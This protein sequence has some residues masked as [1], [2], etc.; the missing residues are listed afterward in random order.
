MEDSATR[1]IG[2]TPNPKQNAHILSRLTF[3]YIFPLFFKGYRRTI[4]EDDVFE[5]HSEL[6]S[7]N[8]GAIGLDLWKIELE[9]ASEA[10]RKPSLIK[11]LTKI[12]LKDY[13]LIGAGIFLAELILRPLQAFFLGEFIL[14]YTDVENERQPYIYASCVIAC[15]FIHTLIMHPVLYASF[16]L[17]FRIR[18]VCGNLIYWKILKLSKNALKQSTPG[19]ILNLIS[20]DVNVF[21]KLVFASQFLWAAPFQAIIVTSLMYREV[22]VSSIFGVGLF[23]LFIPLYFLFGQLVAKFRSK[24]STMRDQRLRFMNEIIQGIGVI[25]M[26]AWEK[27]FSTTILN[28]RKME[29]NFTK[30][31]LLVKSATLIFD[32]FISTSLFITITSGVF[33]NQSFNPKSVFIVTTLLAILGVTLNFLLPQGMIFLSE[34]LVSLDRITDFLLSNEI[35]RKT[36]ATLP[37]GSISITNGTAAWDKMPILRNLNFKIES[38][39]LNAII[40]PIASGKTSLLSLILGEMP[41]TTGSL[42]VSGTISYAPQVAWIFS[43]TIKQNILFG[44]KMDH[45]RYDQVI[46]CCA[47]ERDLKLLPH[48]DQT[49]VGERGSSL[50]GG[51]KARINLARAIYREA[52]IYLLDDPLSA[53]DTEVG[54][55]IFEQ[56]I[57]TFLKGKTVMLVTHQ[58][59]YLKHINSI[60]VLETGSLITKG[61]K[62]E[63]ENSGFDFVHFLQETDMNA[64]DPP[65]ETM[66]RY[67]AAHTASKQPTERLTT[68]LIT[69]RTYKDYFFASKDC[70]I[71]MVPVLL[72]ILVQLSVS[73][74]YYFLAYWVNVEHN[75]GI[76]PEQRSAYLY[77]YCS[78]ILAALILTVCR[79]L[80]FVKLTATSSR[81]LHKRM[82]D[83]V[84]HA[85]LG[86]FNLNSSGVILNRFSKDL[87]TIDELLPNAIMIATRTV[88]AILGV[89]CVICVVNPWFIIPTLLV[90]ATL[91]FLRRFY[92]ATDLNVLR[93][94]GQVRGPL[95]SHVNA[96]LH[97]LATI[98]AFGM[99]DLLTEEFYRHQ[100]IHT[101]ALDMAAIVSRAFAYW[102]DLLNV[103]YIVVLTLYYTFNADSYGGNIGLII[104]QALQL[105]A[106]LPWGV[107]QATDAESFMVSVERVAEYDL[108][109]RE[110]EDN[111]VPPNS[112]PDRGQIEFKDVYLRYNEYAPYALKDLNMTISSK[113][114][115]GIV[116]RTGAGKSSIIAALF[117]LVNI[118]GSISIDNVDICSLNLRDLRAKMSIIPQD[119]VLFTSSIRNNLD[120]FGEYDDEILWK[121]LEEVR[122]KDVVLNLPSGLN[123][124][125]SQDGS[126]FSV[127]QRQLL[128]LARAIVK[129]NKILI[130]DEATANVDMETDTLIQETIR[131]QFSNCTV[132]TVAHRLNTIIDSDKVLVMDMGVAVEFDHPHLLLQNQNGVFY[133]LVQ[134]TGAV[135][136]EILADMAKKSYSKSKT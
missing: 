105:M 27:S 90:V 43:S 128:C 126:N 5:I 33:L 38:G 122:L 106:Q 114:K 100:D 85:T 108:I 61:T 112:W 19:Q 3:F 1:R 132:L 131:T 99:Q 6:K 101:S 49:V 103:V 110:E 96:S 104:S 127:G 115:I 30:F 87:A 94:E 123:F 56:C 11:L 39:S 107:R 25:K 8:L 63:L 26:Y 91:N 2:N 42:N 109:D 31:G 98:R 92:L 111:R 17:A 18:V 21:D 46:K 133:N 86:F 88:L 80:Y 20:N 84:L 73:S 10:N 134:Q 32:V 82:F 75:Y 47:L 28:I 66:A 14:C 16:N 7:S 54:K 79:S 74:S 53:V 55:Q 71:L 12:F 40:G 95:Y 76:L 45:S 44:S 52:D 129:D 89:F 77:V 36:S 57:Q 81:I 59:Q 78:I 65:N 136:A 37:K 124:E 70:V 102:M 23:V 67:E 51:Q 113:Q 72:F 29:I 120:P 9:V 93:A 118:D 50:S 58:L 24:A 119:P 34:I 68:G 135:M 35:K 48:G 62:S 69:F 116:G 64:E 130:L 97:G 83:N 121:A 15:V 60:M 125:I 22:G 41:M 13:L 4:T 117:R